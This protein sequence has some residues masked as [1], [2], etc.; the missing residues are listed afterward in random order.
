MIVIQMM[1]GRDESVP[2]LALA[3]PDQD[4][5]DRGQ[6][7][8]VSGPLDLADH[9]AR[10]GPFDH[11]ST[12]ADPEQAYGKCKKAYDQEPIAHGVLPCPPSAIRP[13]AMQPEW[14]TRS[15]QAMGRARERGNNLVRLRRHKKA[16]DDAGAFE[17]NKA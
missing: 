15:P 14:R 5:A 1:F 7:S 16:P 2:D 11:A 12:L 10:L 8:A 6:R 4:Q 3:L 17:L 9:E 13:G